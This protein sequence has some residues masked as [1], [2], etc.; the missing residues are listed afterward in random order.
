[1]A[2]MVE[3]T[4]RGDSSGVDRN[5]AAGAFDRMI[6]GSVQPKAILSWHWK[7]PLSPP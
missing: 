2:L 3:T 7:V 1:M 5:Q 4:Q 6:A